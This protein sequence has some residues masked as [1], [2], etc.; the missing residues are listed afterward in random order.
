MADPPL[1]AGAVHA[2]T[3]WELALDVAVTPVEA[4]GVP[5]LMDPEAAEA[6]P[7][8]AELMAATVNVYV[9]PVVR[10]LTVHAVVAVEQ[11]KPP[12]LEVTV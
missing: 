12:G 7:V 9:D 11:V 6:A 4:P 3:D 10:P 8:P 1:A 2:T 5:T